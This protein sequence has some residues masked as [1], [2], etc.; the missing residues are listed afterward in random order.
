MVADPR[1]DLPALCGRVH[2]AQPRVTQ[3]PLVAAEQLDH[4]GLS[5]H[6][7]RQPGEHDAS[8]HDQHDARDDDPGQPAGG[9]NDDQDESQGGDED[10]ARQYRKAGERG[11]RALMQP[12]LCVDA[13]VGP[14]RSVLHRGT[15]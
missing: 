2:P 12:R 15:S 8:D 4:A 7:R 6:D 9:S 1:Q 5:R 14:Q 13:N 11:G 3:R 10:G